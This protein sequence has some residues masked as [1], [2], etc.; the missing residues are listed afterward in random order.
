MKHWITGVVA[1]QLVSTEWTWL[2][3]ET[4]PVAARVD[5]PA[6]GRAVVG[7]VVIIPPAARERVS[8]FR[9]M[10]YLS[11]AAAAAG[12]VA[13][14]IDLPGDGDSPRAEGADLRAD[15]SSAVRAAED[16]ARLLAPGA[17][18]HEVGLRIGACLVSEAPPFT[19]EVRLMWQPV[20]GRRFL[21]QQRNARRVGVRV[22]PVGEGVE[23]PGHLYSAADAEAMAKLVPPK[24]TAQDFGYTVRNEGDPAVAARIAMSPPPAAL[25]PHASVHEIVDALPRG[26]AVE[27]SPW[28]PTHAAVVAPG[29]VETIGRLGPQGLRFVMTKPLTGEP[30]PV[31]LAFTAIGS[32]VASGPGG[33]WTKLSRDF[34]SRGVTSLRADRNGLGEAVFPEE[35]GEAACYTDQAVEDTADLVAALRNA[36]HPH[37]IIGV[38]ACS[39]AWCFLRAAEFVDIERVVAVNS[40]HWAPDTR[41]Y[42]EA[43]YDRQHDGQRNSGLLSSGEGAGRGRLRHHYAKATWSLRRFADVVGET[44][45]GDRVGLMAKRLR[46]QTRVDVLMGREETV[47]FLLKGGGWQVLR[48]RMRV[49]TIEALDHSLLSEEARRIV[50]LHIADHLGRE[51]RRQR[52]SIGALD[53]A[54]SRTAMSGVN[55]RL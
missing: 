13:V 2:R 26:E 5:H 11:I 14:T 51:Q 19:D 18:M 43:F 44:L 8:A 15:W 4:S 12:F 42:D 3:T 27:R 33:L 24:P 39:G 17:P 35:P 28:R 1:A 49:V 31:A 30:A 10:R 53:R 47:R 22:A 50:A 7:S 16:L 55:S 9:T 32:E 6:P 52:V 37:E 38:G 20:S 29:V 23:F 48:R 46:P 36:A 40:V 41:V 34:A 54:E 21:R 25:I 45:R